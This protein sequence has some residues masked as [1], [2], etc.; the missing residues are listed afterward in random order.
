MQKKI[1]QLIPKLGIGPLSSEIIEAAFIY[2]EERSL[3]LMLI[4]SKNQI[5][6]QGGYV[7]NW[8]TKK[9]SKFLETLKKKYPKSD[10]WVC[11][12]HCGPGFNGTNSLDV[13]IKQLIQI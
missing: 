8:T 3:P 9:Y 13:P 4:A 12:D 1:S 2:S 5:D 6:Y 10:I 7:N 11:R